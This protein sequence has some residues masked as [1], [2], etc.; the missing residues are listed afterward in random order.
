MH[1]EEKAD[2]IIERLKNLNC[3]S[4]ALLVAGSKPHLRSSYKIVKE[5]PDITLDEFLD[6]LEK[7]KVK[8]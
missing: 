8:Q 2:F 4:Y 7:V 5:N 1:L 6:E 3:G